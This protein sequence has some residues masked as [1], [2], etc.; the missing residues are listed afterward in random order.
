MSELEEQHTCDKCHK[1]GEDKLCM[2][3]YCAVCGDE[4]EGGWCVECSANEDDDDES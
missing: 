1:V 3:C 2:E 4:L